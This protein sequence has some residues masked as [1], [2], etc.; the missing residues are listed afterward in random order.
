VLVPVKPPA[1]A[2]S[3]LAPLGDQA[4]RALVVAFALDTVVAAL[5]TRIV[6]GV[7]AVTDDHALA[8]ALRDVGAFVI[9]DAVTDDLNGSLRQAA[10]EAQRRWPDCGVAALCADLPALRTVDLERA[11][12]TAPTDQ[13]SFVADA[14][15][16]GTTTVLAPAADRFA[17]LFGPE[18]R[19]AHLEAGAV[20]IELDVPTLRH[21]VD[22]SAD[23]AVALDLGVGTRTSVAAA[24]LSL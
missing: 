8:A 16:V 19:T 6:R 11:L 1:F 20:E 22:T 18:S 23:L 3:R 12:T 5:E 4:R 21:D 17:P 10:L 13:M 24:G 14:D 9:P 15:G 7:L 2:K